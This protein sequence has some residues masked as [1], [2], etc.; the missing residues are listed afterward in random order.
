MPEVAGSLWSVAAE[1]QLAAAERLRAAGLRRLHWD[2]SDGRF[3]GS[4]GFT[5]SRA[6]ALTEATGLAAE[7]HIMAEDPLHEIDAWTDFCDLIVIHAESRNWTRAADRI[8]ARGCTPGLAISPQT[9]ATIVPADLAVLCMSIAPGNAGSAFDETVLTKV[10]ALREAAPERRIGLDGGVQR[11]HVER[12]E[13]AGANW[14]VVGTDLFL[15][16]AAHRWAD[17]LHLNA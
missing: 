15:G 3:A 11:R 16:D 17:I 5:A 8:A 7:A 2:M 14:I 10:S 4:G 13:R 9:P 6:Q 1:E 12:A